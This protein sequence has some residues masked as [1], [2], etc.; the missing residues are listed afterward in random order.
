MEEIIATHFKK[1]SFAMGHNL[2]HNGGFEAKKKQVVKSVNIWDPTTC[3]SSG[4][5]TRTPDTRIMIEYP[6]NSP[7]PFIP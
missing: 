7:K 6:R 3:H 5:G 1:K 2:G 4:A